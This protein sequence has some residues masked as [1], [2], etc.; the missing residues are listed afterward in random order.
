M[1][2]QRYFISFLSYRKCPTFLTPAASN[3]FISVADL[4]CS[5][6]FVCLFTVLF[7]ASSYN[8]PVQLLTQLAPALT[9]IAFLLLLLLT[10][11]V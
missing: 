5:V 7:T 11:L 2:T 1:R 3:R 9:Q 10:R 4:R 8:R 6:C